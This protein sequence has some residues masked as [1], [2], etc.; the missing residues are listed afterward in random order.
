LIEAAELRSFAGIK[1]SFSV[2]LYCLRP[3]DSGVE[4]FFI[5]GDLAQVAG[6]GLNP[7]NGLAS[8]EEERPRQALLVRL[9]SGGWS[10]V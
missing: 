1:R 2:S 8:Q 7:M 6:R 4:L 5:G 10:G 3:F 9:R